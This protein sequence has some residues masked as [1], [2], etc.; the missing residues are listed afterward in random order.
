MLLSGHVSRAVGG[1]LDIEDPGTYRIVTLDVGGISWR[2]ATA[3]SPYQHGEFLV[4]A[5]KDVMTGVIAIRCYGVDAAALQSAVVDLLAAFAQ[6]SYNVNVTINGEAHEWSCEPAD[7]QMNQGQG[8]DKFAE[9]AKQQLWVFH[10]PR[11]P[12]PVEGSY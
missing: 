7:A 4:G 11:S 2:R 9:G 1:N 8:F 6:F 10:F 5:V 12:I 3:K